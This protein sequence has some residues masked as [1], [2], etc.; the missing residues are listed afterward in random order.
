MNMPM[1]M[2]KNAKEYILK[3][4]KL[5]QEAVKHFSEIPKEQRLLITSE[6]AFKIS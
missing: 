2:E 3:L 6:G 5:H 4:E 1:F